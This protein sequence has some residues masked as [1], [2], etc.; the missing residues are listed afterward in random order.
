MVL[1]SFAT[2]FETMTQYQ[3]DDRQDVVQLDAMARQVRW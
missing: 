3:T 2:A 1:V